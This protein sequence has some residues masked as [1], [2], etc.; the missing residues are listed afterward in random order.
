MLVVL[1]FLADPLAQQIIQTE[2]CMRNSTV[3][4]SR[5]SR[6]NGYFA[7]GGSFGPATA[8]IDAPMAVAINTGIV[9]PPENI[10]S[11]IFTECSSGNCTFPMFRTV[12]VCHSCE[13][14]SQNVRKSGT[15]IFTNYT[16]SDSSGNPTGLWIAHTRLFIGRVESMLVGNTIANMTYM[17][18]P[19]QIGQ[20]DIPPAAARC[21]LFPCVRDYKSAMQKFVLSE[22]LLSQERI[23]MNNLRPSPDSGLLVTTKIIRNGTWQ[24]CQA[25]SEAGSGLVQVAIANVDASPQDPPRYDGTAPTAWYPEDCVWSFGRWSTSVIGQA[26]KKE[27]DGISITSTGETPDGSIPARNLWLNGTGNLNTT[28][29][30]ISDLAD[31]MTATI[32][33]RG[34]A[35][36]AKYAQGQV[37]VNLTCV[38]VEWTW[39]SALAILTVLSFIFLVLLIFQSPNGEKIWKSS[40]LATLHCGIDERI[41]Q[42]TGADQT[43]DDIFQAAKATKAQLRKDSNG[44][45]QFI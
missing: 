36:A 38:K 30:F 22:D 2:D 24:T 16:L 19:G 20:Y 41:A 34:V 35:G 42:S 40:T 3:L 37:A 32:R 15:D 6:T 31:T 39:I 4:T 29:T 28:N 23:G 27:L 10:S 8:V 7:Q 18:G 44:N 9:S 13:D 5:I 43:R 26:L 45:E 12:G 14:I 25:S 11:L 1:A 21:Q 33:R 17:I